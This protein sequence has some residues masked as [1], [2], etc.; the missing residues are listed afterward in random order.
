MSRFWS[1]A[2]AIGVLASVENASAQLPCIHGEASSNGG[3]ILA[4]PKGDGPTLASKG[5]TISIRVL[6][7]SGNPVVGLPKK[8]MWLTAEDLVHC[9][10]GGATERPLLIAD[11]PTDTAGRTTFSGALM[12]S[13]CGEAGL[14]VLVRINHGGT[15]V[16]YILSQD[17]PGDNPPF[18]CAVPWQLP[19]MVRS[20][21]LNGDGA[22][23]LSD[24]SLFSAVYQNGPFDTCYDFDGSGTMNAPD[25]AMFSSH[26]GNGQPTHQCP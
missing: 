19:I 1:V 10:I 11:A 17:L 6:D 16:T 3:V 25:L 9:Y 13:G 18:E 21:D 22:V 2:A 5:L 24:F 23:T 7:G 15:P 4:C 20:P 26:Y 8:D 12:G 14:S